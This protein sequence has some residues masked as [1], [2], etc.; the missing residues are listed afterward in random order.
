VPQ[1]QSKPQ[2][3]AAEAVYHTVVAGETLYRIATKYHTTVDKIIFLNN[4]KNADKIA[5][6]QKLRVK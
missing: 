6:G 5:E 4:L 1:A 2:E 3:Q